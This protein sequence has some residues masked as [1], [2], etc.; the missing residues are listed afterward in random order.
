MLFT[1]AEN[2]NTTFL[3]ILASLLDFD[4]RNNPSIVMAKTLVLVSRTRAPPW[5]A[6]KPDELWF[7][8][9]SIQYFFQLQNN[10]FDM[11]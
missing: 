7:N 1:G 11:V 9:C 4:S 3:S 8:S 2:I 10:W 6:Q 5:F